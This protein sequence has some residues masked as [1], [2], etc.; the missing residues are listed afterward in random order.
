[1]Q[2]SPTRNRSL[3]GGAA[4]NF[5]QEAKKNS[6]MRFRPSLSSIFKKWKNGKKT[7][8]HHA[9]NSKISKKKQ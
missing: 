8:A 4:C 9:G 2:A 6:P 5:V 3:A 7:L 1:M